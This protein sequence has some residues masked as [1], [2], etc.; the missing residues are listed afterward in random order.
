VDVHLRDDNNAVIASSV[1]HEGKTRFFFSNDGGST[2]QH[3][4]FYEDQANL[5]IRPLKDGEILPWDPNPADE[6]VKY[7]YIYYPER[8]SYDE[9]SI[10][11]GKTWT[12]IKGI[13]LGCEAEIDTNGMYYYHPREPLTL[14]QDGNLPESDSGLG[15]LGMFAST[16]GGDT[17][18]F[19]YQSAFVP[20]LA[21]SQSNPEVMYGAGMYGS[22]LKS[23]DGGKRW[24]LVGQNDLIRRTRE[25]ANEGDKQSSEKSFNEWPTDIE[26]IA[27]DPVDENRIYLA[28]SKGLLRSENGGET[29]CILNTGINEARAI[30]NVAVCPKQPNILLVGTYKGLLRSVDRGCRWEWIDILSRITQR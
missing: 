26:D 1:D 23:T 4:Q 25:V 28:T 24:D 30:H 18:R 5:W 13:V 16:N 3:D 14:Y 10:D 29:W 19:M 20:M 21:I 11:G 8:K 7:R 17:F 12:R 6:N 22:L 9:R 27:I 15:A 2:W